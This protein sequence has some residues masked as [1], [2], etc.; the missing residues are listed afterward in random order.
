MKLTYAKS[1]THPASSHMQHAEWSSSPVPS[2]VSTKLPSALADVFGM[3]VESSRNSRPLL[4]PAAT[5]FILSRCKSV[6]TEQ[7][8]I[9]ISSEYEKRWEQSAA[10]NA[11][12]FPFESPIQTFESIR[13]QHVSFIPFE[14]LLSSICCCWIDVKSC[15]HEILWYCCQPCDEH[16]NKSMRE[17][18]QGSQSSYPSACSWFDDIG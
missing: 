10:L 5:R 17:L 7:F 2:S 3:S 8:S 18:E 11:W 6:T 13:Q 16:S 15:G 1:L 14:L 4:R 12:I 9:A